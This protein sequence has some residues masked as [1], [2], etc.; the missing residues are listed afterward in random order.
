MFLYIIL[1]KNDILSKK[2]KTYNM[3]IS[4]TFRY[5]RFKKYVNLC[6]KREACTEKVRTAEVAWCLVN[7]LLSQ[8]L[9]TN[10]AKK[11][12]SKKD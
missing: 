7:H 10:G 11:G 2:S 9:A 4:R 12:I 1:Y 3:N 8:T 6:P 5:I